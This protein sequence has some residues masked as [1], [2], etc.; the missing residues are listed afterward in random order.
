MALDQSV[1]GSDAFYA[2][3][4]TSSPFNSAT[5]P[6]SASNVMSAPGSIS[7]HQDL[8][9]TISDTLG[10]EFSEYV[11]RIKTTPYGQQLLPTLSQQYSQEQ[12]GLPFDEASSA[13]PSSTSS[14]GD[15]SSYTARVEFGLKLGYTEA[16]VQLALIKLGPSAGQN[17]LLAELIKLGA[18][19]NN[20][21]GGSQSANSGIRSTVSS[22]QP[23]LRDQ[24]IGGNGDGCAFLDE[25]GGGC[26]SGADSHGDLSSSETGGLRHIVIDGSNVAM[27]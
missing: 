26:L 13:S 8:C 20:N 6:P 14:F 3:S 25:P 27:R 15:C 1:P 7:P 2:S 10:A 5:P 21:A 23:D 17:E 12:T 11:T 9:R 4:S 24:M 18:V 16:Q 22:S 19:N